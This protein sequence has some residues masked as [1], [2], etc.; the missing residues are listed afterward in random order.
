[1]RVVR[2]H[3]PTI[4][5]SSRLVPL[6]EGN[7]FDDVALHNGGDTSWQKDL[8]SDQAFSRQNKPRSTKPQ[9]FQ[10]VLCPLMILN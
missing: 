9:D 5:A 2:E 7:Q 4:F 6:G 1:M 10:V 8:S 3:S